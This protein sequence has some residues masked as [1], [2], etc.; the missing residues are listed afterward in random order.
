MD[1]CY[2]LQH[3]MRSLDRSGFRFRTLFFGITVHNARSIRLSISNLFFGFSIRF[4]IRP[5]CRCGRFMSWYRQSLDSKMIDDPCV[6]FR[7]PWGVPKE[8]SRFMNTGTLFGF[9]G[10]QVFQV[11]AHPLM[12]I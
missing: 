3:V 10:L 6:P 7:G 12:C 11:E 9:P 1:R 5:Q 2:L 4:R 8:V